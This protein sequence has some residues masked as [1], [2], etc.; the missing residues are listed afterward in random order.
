MEFKFDQNANQDF[1]SEAK[2]AIIVGYFYQEIGDKLL[3]AAQQTL[4]KYGANSQTIEI[5]YCSGAFEIPLIAQNLAKTNNYDGIITLGAVINGETPHFDYICSQCA[6]GVASVGL[7]YNLPIS[8]GVLTTLNMEQTL[9]RAGGYRGNKGVE[10]S[11]ALIET[12]YLLA[13]IKS[14]NSNNGI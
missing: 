14:N 7:K 13:Q 4:A 11:L 1:L 8:F 12:M 3:I 5:Y 10:A 2:I 9:G 6:N